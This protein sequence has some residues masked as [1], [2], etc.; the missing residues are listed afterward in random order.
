MVSHLRHRSLG[1]RPAAR[2]PGVLPL[3]L[4]VVL[5]LAACDSPTAAGQHP[6]PTG[7]AT[8]PPTATAAAALQPNDRGNLLASP[9]VGQEG[10]L[11]AIASLPTGTAWAVGQF[12]GPDA[13][14]QTLTEHWDGTRWSY[15]PSPSPGQ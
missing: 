6:T 14:Q 13:V 5:L 15:V 9:P 3:S 10:R 4:V 2:I 7:T 12:Q 1:N 8:G 11:T